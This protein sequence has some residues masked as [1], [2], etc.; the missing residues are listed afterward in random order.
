M[1]AATALGRRSRKEP[2]QPGGFLLSHTLWA[3]GSKSSGRE[4]GHRTGQSLISI[5]FHNI[6]I[7]FSYL[8]FSK[9]LSLLDFIFLSFCPGTSLGRS[10]SF[11][12]QLLNRD[13]LPLSLETDGCLLF[14]YKMYTWHFSP[15]IISTFS[16]F[17][18]NKNWIYQRKVFCYLR[19]AF[20]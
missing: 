8:F 5:F 3:E 13:V 15:K 6:F 19:H 16:S 17:T 7:V 20:L 14:I 12:S 11:E 18:K 4:G 9:R 2:L 10:Y 1:L